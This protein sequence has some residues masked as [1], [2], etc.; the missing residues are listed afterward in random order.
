MYLVCFRSWSWSCSNS[1]LRKAILCLCCFV[2]WDVCSILG[3]FGVQEQDWNRSRKCNSRSHN[4]RKRY[5]VVSRRTTGLRV[6]GIVE[7]FNRCSG[8]PT[9]IHPFS[10]ICM[11]TSLRSDDYIVNRERHLLHVRA[12]KRVPSSLQHHLSARRTAF[13]AAFC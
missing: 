10:H 13:A 8:R 12:V 9:L 2:G 11:H 7:L 5:L 3:A 4:I 6:Y 1:D